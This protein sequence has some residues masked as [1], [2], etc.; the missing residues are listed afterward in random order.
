[1]GITQEDYDRIQAKFDKLDEHI[2]A[3][4]A[5]IARANKLLSK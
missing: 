5:H 3:A 4:R 1:M 2:D